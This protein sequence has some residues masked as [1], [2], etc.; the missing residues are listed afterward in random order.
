[1]SHFNAHKRLQLEN[2]KKGNRLREHR[3]SHLW[4]SEDTCPPNA[5]QTFVD[6]RVLGATSTFVGR[7]HVPIWACSRV[8]DFSKGQIGC[9]DFDRALFVQ[10]QPVECCNVSTPCSPA[11]QVLS[12]STPRR[13]TFDTAY[14]AAYEKLGGSLNPA[15]ENHPMIRLFLNLDLKL[16]QASHF[17]SRVIVRNLLIYEVNLG[18]ITTE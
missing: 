3:M 5:E 1:M 7:S 9:L 16:R 4:N 17:L 10:R 18:S 8:W 13:L 11:E 14:P 15:S 6:T 2:R 12:Y